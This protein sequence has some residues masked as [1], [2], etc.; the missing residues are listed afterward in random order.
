MEKPSSLLKRS[1]SQIPWESTGIGS[2]QKE[3]K[4]GSKKLRV[5]RLDAKFK[6]ESWCEKGHLGVV[7]EGEL[8]LELEDSLVAYSKGD[9]VT[10][11][12]GP[13][14]K[15]KAKIAV[16]GFVEIILFEESCQNELT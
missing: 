9:C 2:W 5:L 8:T 1:L 15:H 11:P 10:I 14:H 4:L 13:N 12:E 6:E 3:V 16:D 7:I